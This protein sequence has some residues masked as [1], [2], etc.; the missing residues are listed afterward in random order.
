MQTITTHTNIAAASPF[1]AHQSEARWFGDGLWEFLVPSEVTDGKL[2]VFRATMPQGFS[3]PR[4][5]HTREDE[6]FLVL[7]GH[8]CFD[9]DGD[10]RAAG[11][12]TTVYVPRGVPHTFRIQSAVGRMLGVMAPGA[13]EQLFR[14]LSV[15]AAERALPEPGT[16]PF[17]ISA[18]MAEQIRLGTE[19]VGPPMA[20]EGA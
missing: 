13:F 8:V 6:V 20:A 4:H 2:S 18:V 9:L 10:R 1:L 15:P 3:P 7:D 5:I 11:P 14:R 17:D 19:V 12:G 16:V